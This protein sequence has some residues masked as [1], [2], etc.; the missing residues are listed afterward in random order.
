V[1]KEPGFVSFT[2]GESVTG[3]QGA[4]R[5]Y[6][7]KGDR[8][9]DGDAYHPGGRGSTFAVALK[10]GLPQGTYTAT[11]RVV[12]ADT[13]IVTGGFVFSIGRRGGSPSATVG[14]LLSD[15]RTGSVTSTAFAVT[16]A[17]QYG[18]IGV[19]GG[20]L[21]F[22][23]L[24]WIPALRRTGN[25]TKRWRLG[26]EQSA[27]RLRVG[28]LVAA[29]VGL[30]SACIGL[31]LQGAESAGITLWRSFESSVI[32]AVLKTRFGTV[33]VAAG[34][35]WSFVGGWSMLALS[36]RWSSGSR[37]RTLWTPSPARLAPL[38]VAALALVAL[39]AL[40]GHA[41]VQ[42]PVWLFLPTNLVHVGAMSVWLGGLTALL[43]CVP[44]ATR[45]LEG[46]DRTR[47]LA[48][49]LARFSPIALGCVLVL[50]TTGV[51]QAL[52]EIDE[53]S[54]L[55][56]TPLGRA[57]LV[58]VALLAALIALGA[59][60]R[61]RT[62][63]QLNALAD[64]GATP[65]AVGAALRQT[66]R[67]E[68]AIIGVV[69]IVTG[70]LSGYAPAKTVATGPVAVN[71]TLGPA[72]LSLDVDPARVGGNEIHIY[73]LNPK[74]GAQY[75]A[76]K[77]LTVTAALPDKNIGPLPLSAQDTG[78][79][80]YTISDAVLGPSGTWT[81]DLTARISAFD[82]YERKVEVRIR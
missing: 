13:H 45:E 9:D 79:G 23:L 28:L 44:A 17:L 41:S 37:H 33:W 68:V 18:A 42:H 4:I 69:L 7:A 66:V 25:E 43:L 56:N 2:F 55:W 39:P 59:R 26:A 19:A 82:E 36:P 61:I 14:Q 10:P 34:I 1:A 30:L 31:G 81:L 5:V 24:V 73:L 53:F 35:V 65:G 11:Y 75:T 63:P 58:K 80:H 78:P 71:T 3:T 47:L 76:V 67:A 12:S 29:A 48:A 27:R 40:A 6:G 77:Q 38:L 49:T 60:N 8:V 57:V 50:L 62:V 20:L 72:Q 21:V 70:A 52:L 74:T 46:H 15:Q 16:R 64:R 22:W 54:E 32:S 51:V